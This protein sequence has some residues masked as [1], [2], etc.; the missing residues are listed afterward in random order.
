MSASVPHGWQPAQPTHWRRAIEAT[1]SARRKSVGPVF[2][3]IL[4]MDAGKGDATPI[5]YPDASPVLVHRGCMK[6]QH[7]EVETPIEPYFDSQSAHT[8]QIAT[9]IN[10][11]YAPTAMLAD[12]NVPNS[13]IPRRALPGPS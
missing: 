10:G 3:T 11:D 7:K 13:S 6:E 5:T 9:F 8:E 2:L 12:P 1:L 4:V